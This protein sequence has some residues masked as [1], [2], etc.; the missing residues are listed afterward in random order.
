M[1]SF[2]GVELRLGEGKISGSI[3][4]F[5]GAL[6]VLGV[7]CFHFP[8]YLTT[9]KLRAQYDIALLRNILWGAMIVSVVFGSITFFLWRS[10]RLGLLG[11]AL[12]LV[13]QWLGGASVKVNEFE[14]PVVSF[15]LDW[16][17]LAL[18]ANT[19]V[20]VLIERVIPHRKEQLILRKEWKLDFAYYVF[21]HLMIS[22][23]LLI[24][25]LF[26][27]TLFGWAVHDG[28]QALIRRQPVFVQFFE[29]LFVAD[30][31]QYWGHRMMHENKALWRIHAVHHCP[32]EMDWLS[33][34]R[35]HFFEVLFTRSTILVPIYLLGFSNAAINAYVVWVGIQAVLIHANTGIRFGFLKYLFT[36][37]HF[38]HWHH[39]ADAEAIDKN[40]AAHLPV[41]DWI[42]GTYLGNH[43]RWPQRYGVVGKSLPQGFFAQHLYPFMRNRD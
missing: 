15:G 32:A 11:I 4:V 14:E 41:L 7:L 10:K 17:I 38:H 9:A 27:E 35:V 40:Y 1:S 24:T 34:S 5:L 12:T 18:L 39:A 20:F 2:E 42:F 31:V 33:G 16:L 29:V 6:C 37:P 13:A 19:L 21:N 30:F 25:T 8:E 28:V 43:D 23:I 22:V 3:S 26:S 36:T